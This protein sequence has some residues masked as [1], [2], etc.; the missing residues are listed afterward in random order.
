[1]KQTISMLV[2][3]DS[4]MIR[5]IFMDAAQVSRRPLRITATD[6][7]RDCLTLLKSGDVD[8]AFIDVNIPELSG[9]DAIWAARK[10]GVQTFVTIMS[11]PPSPEAVEMARKLKAYE[12]LFKPFEL[13]DVQAIMRTYERITAPSKVLLVDDSQTVRRVI[14]KVLNGSIF[15]CEITEAPDGETAIAL[16]KETAFDA[17]FLDRVMPGL[18]GMDTLERLLELRP[19]L[20]VVMISGEHD[21]ALERKAVSLGAV[22][23]LHKPFYSADVDRVL[24]QIYGIRS[25]NLSLE[26]SEPDFDVAVEGSTIRLAHKDSGHTFEYL[27]FKNPPH[28]RNATV[29]PGVFQDPELERLMAAAERSALLQLTS[30]RLLTAA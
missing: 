11:S 26:R 1:M 18:A 23:F 5:K 4:R 9:L 6:N 20:K 15:N 29:P 21:E 13:A 25:P 16:C 22:E 17:V 12:F 8:M 10:L 28:L 3:D 30:A 2:A 7:G 24:H 14:Q 27:W 19:A